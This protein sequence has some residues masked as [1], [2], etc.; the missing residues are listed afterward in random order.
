M[1]ITDPYQITNVTAG[2]TISATFAI[3]RFTISASSG[4]N[5]SIA[6]AGD[7]TVDYGGSQPYTITPAPGYH[8]AGVLVDGSPVGTPTS[9]DFSGV[10]AGHT[11]SATFAS[12]S[13]I[14][15]LAEGSTDWGFD[16]YVSVENPND[17][18]VDRQADLHDLHRAGGRAHREH[19]RQL[20]GHRLPRRHP[21]GRDFSTKVECLEGK[22]HQRGPDH[23]LD[24]GRAPPAPEA[25]CS[26][27]VTSPAT[28]WY[29]PEGSSAWG[30]ECW[31]LI[32]NPNAT[33]RHLPGHL[34][35]RGRAPADERLHA[36]PP[37]RRATFNMADDI[38]A[39]RRLHQG[40]RRTS[41]SSRERAMYRNNRREGHDSIGTTTPATDYYLA[42]GST[43]LGLHHL[44]AGAEPA[45]TPHRRDHHLHDRRRPGGQ[46]PP[47]PCRPTRARP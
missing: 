17:E 27:G 40:G 35:D 45:T 25:H 39:A 28:T 9:Y 47:S 41:R 5:G 31:L 32:Q 46:A 34:H 10:T 15:Y 13:A 22:S 38:G 6:P 4:G 21:G 3:D 19:A 12:D 2:H 7:T 18:A 37:T 26:I 36:C 8:L 30:F 42:E 23:V 43:G 24:R 14:W 1:T 16:C 33:C 11:I 44:R 29:L 20:P